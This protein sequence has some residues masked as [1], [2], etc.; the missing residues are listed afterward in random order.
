ML[1]AKMTP[2]WNSYLWIKLTQDEL[3]VVLGASGALGSA[4]IRELVKQGK[5][6]R[7]ANRSG[8]AKVPEGSKLSRRM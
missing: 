1:N 6:V 8:I 7:G 2:V 3:F 4:I 5:T